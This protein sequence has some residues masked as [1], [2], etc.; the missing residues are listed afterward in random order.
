[1]M[2]KSHV[3]FSAMLTAAAL[4]ITNEVLGL[5]L[6][7]AEMAAGV[8]IGG[9]AG[10]LPDIDHPNSLITQGV[11]PG[12]KL[13]GPVGKTVG[14]VLC[15]PPR[16][17]GVGA[18]ATM[19]HRGGT[20]SATFLVG[21]TLLAAPFYILTFTALAFILSI[22]LT[23]ILALLGLDFNFSPGGVWDWFLHN[24]KS[25][26]FL[27]SPAVF[28]GYA[29]H[30]IADSMTKVPVPWPW[31]FSHRR[32]FLLP[33]PMRIT[34]GSSTETFLLRPIF[35]LLLILFFAWNIA[36]PLGQEIFTS[37][38]KTV[39]EQTEKENSNKQSKKSAQKNQNQQKQNS[40]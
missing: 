13:F 2:G 26:M 17:I 27:V 14:Y 10:V 1:M 36:I 34:T 20:H 33:K 21:W 24:A 5:G 4:P 39:Q 9:V 35:I 19:N 38:D 3:A 11:V 31:P 32:L 40:D 25:V 12:S 29:G 8:V 28:W 6:S 23:P 16:I 15:I 7:P 18:R 37:V 30:L 22:I